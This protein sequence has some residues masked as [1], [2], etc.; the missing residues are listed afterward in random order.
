M[1]FSLLAGVVP[2]LAFADTWLEVAKS[3]SVDGVAG[4]GTL[5]DPVIVEKG[6][7][8]DY[9]VTVTNDGDPMTAPGGDLGIGE[10]VVMVV[11][12]SY[13]TLAVTTRGDVYAWGANNYGQLGLGYFTSSA[14]YGIATPQK[15]ETLSPGG[16]IFD[17]SGAVTQLVTGSDFTVA[18]TESGDIY[19]WGSGFNGD[20]GIGSNT[21]QSTPQ[22]ISLSDVVELAGGG[23]FVVARTATGD[24]YSW[25]WNNYGQLGLGDN[26][27][28]GT[29][30]R[31]WTPSLIASI[32]SGG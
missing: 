31:N 4:N 2:T 23:S 19:S 32:S 17:T 13:H 6:D 7:V 21:N 26:A 10:K 27:V 30:N 5:S 8:I 22:K 18:L 15:I 24:V 20:L 25:G 14:P 28:P 3:A 1:V 29:S 11:A 9:A 12:G 16:D